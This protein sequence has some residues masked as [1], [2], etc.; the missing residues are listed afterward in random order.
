MSKIAAVSIYVDDL[1]VADAGNAV[2][3]LE[4]RAES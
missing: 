1:K 4:L 3:L 2:E